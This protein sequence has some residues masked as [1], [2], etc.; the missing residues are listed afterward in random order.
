MTRIDTVNQ[1]SQKQNDVSV[2]AFVGIDWADQ[3]H[4]GA[5]CPAGGRT[6][7]FEL[8][9]TAEAVDQWAGRMRKRFG[10][11]PI[12]ICLE[13]S[14]G[15][16]IY[17][18]MKYEFFVLYPINPK[19][20]KR[21]REA[22]YPSGA[23]DDPGDAEL[24]LELLLKHRD[25]LHA[26]QPSDEQ[27]RLIG[28]LTED[29]RNLVGE[30]TRLTNAL[31]SRL[32]QYYP[33]ALEVLGEL[34]TELACRFLLQWGSMEELQ[35]ED[36]K[37]IADFY[38][39]YRC[40]HPRLIAERLDK[41]SQA[42]P[43]TTDQAIVQSGRQLV[44]SLA[45]QLLALLEPI[46]EYDQKLS[47]LMEKHP[48]REIF[49]SFPGAGDAMAPRLLAAFGT[50]RERLARAAEM[51][52]ISGIA[53]VTIKSGK[54]QRKVRRRWACNKFLRQTFHEFAQHSLGKSAWAKAYYDMMR[55]KG[56]KHHAAVRALAFKWIRILHRCWKNRTLYNEAHYFQ[57]L[58]Q[59]R[60]PL[61]QFM[62]SNT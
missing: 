26:W 44:R 62:G 32:K 12:A 33:L 47:A 50:D 39:V 40:R 38:R 59:R 31:K 54:T 15:A 30:C 36:P 23:K 28:I 51:Q 45:T 56:L 25:K 14:K 7:S 52:Q 37:E 35:A 58:S 57:Q 8:D 16:L 17:A 22:M 11:Q 41:I 3:K 10:G 1:N 27:T 60:S 21:F 48:D 46:R 5:L 49:Q 20:S 13:Q 2:A 55:S 9:Q 53:P 42:T 6:E 43:L 61:L 34:D 18:L 29:R 24:I 19:Q 4:A